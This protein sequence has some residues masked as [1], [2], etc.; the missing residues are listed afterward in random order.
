MFGE[1][2]GE[3]SGQ[4]LKRNNRNNSRD[5]N[6]KGACRDGN[7]KGARASRARTFFIA[8]PAV[9]SVVPFEKNLD[10][11]FQPNLDQTLAN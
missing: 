2:L 11:K 1:D 9:V 8:V 4:D 10:Q 7:E 5:G 6:E 3:I